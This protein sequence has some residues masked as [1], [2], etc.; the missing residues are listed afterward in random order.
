MKIF[1]ELGNREFSFLAKIL[2]TCDTKICSIANFL[3]HP[4]YLALYMTPLIINAGG[5][6]Y[7]RMG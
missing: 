6:R 4:V 1:T 5:R 7:V 3:C 2:L